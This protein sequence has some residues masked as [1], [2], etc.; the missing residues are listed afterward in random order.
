ML[1]NYIDLKAKV[2]FFEHILHLAAA[3]KCCMD[4]D[5]SIKIIYDITSF[6]GNLCGEFLYDLHDMGE[7]IMQ[8]INGNAT[9]TQSWKFQNFA[10][11]KVW[12]FGKNQNSH[13]PTY[14]KVLS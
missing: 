13:Q 7:I 1:N 6:M 5:A 11:N 9:Q 12:N 4:A 10:K 2:T 3:G 14:P 8:T